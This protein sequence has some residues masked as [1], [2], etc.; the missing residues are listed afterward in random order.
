MRLEISQTAASQSKN[1][2]FNSL[3]G[4]LAIKYRGQPVEILPI[5]DLNEVRRIMGAQIVLVVC[6]WEANQFQNLIK[7][8]KNDSSNVKVIMYV[9]AGAPYSEEIASMYDYSTGSFE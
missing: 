2:N 3:M 6:N 7:I 8:V 9:T 4:T 1:K 5:K